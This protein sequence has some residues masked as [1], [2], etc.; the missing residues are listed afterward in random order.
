MHIEVFQTLADPTRR[1]IIEVLR[2]GELAVNDIVDRMQDD[3][4]TERAIAGWEM[5]LAKLTKIVET[6]P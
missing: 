3:V 4:W 6:K 2:A 1:Q 5:E